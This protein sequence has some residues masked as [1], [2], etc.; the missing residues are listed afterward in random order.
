MLHRY[1]NCNCAC[2]LCFS[3]LN[4]NLTASKYFIT[5]KCANIKNS[6]NLY[7]CADVCSNKLQAMRSINTVDRFNLNTKFR[8]PLVAK[9]IAFCFCAIC[10]YLVVCLRAIIIEKNKWDSMYRRNQKI[11]KYAEEL[12]KGGHTCMTWNEC[13]PGILH[14]CQKEPCRYNKQDNIL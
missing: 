10:A 6:R 1:I 14:W 9:I 2:K 5:N 4:A 8:L 7:L 3:P 13:Y 11:E 12:K